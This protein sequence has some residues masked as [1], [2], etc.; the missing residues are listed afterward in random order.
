M[1]SP[2]DLTKLPPAAQKILDPQGP[3]PLKA[4]AAKAVVPGLKPADLLVVVVLLADGDG[5]AAEIARQT[6]AKLPPPVLNGAL[7][8]DLEPMV[9]GRLV[10]AYANDAA[11]MERLL[12]MPRIALETVETAAAKCSEMVAE[13]IAVNEQRML[14]HPP[15]IERLYMN[16]ATRMSTADRIIELAV[17]NRLELTGIPAYK[18][19]AI[20]IGQELVSEPTEEPTPDDILFRETLE[21][22]KALGFNPE[23]EDTHEVSDEGEE[24]VAKKFLPLYARIGT[25]T[26][27]QKIRIAMLGSAA[28]RMLLMRD[29]NRLVAS[30]AIRSPLIQEPE[31]VRVSASRVVSEEVLR[32]VSLNK[33]WVRNYQVKVNLVQN[34]RT[35]FPTAARLV[36]YLREHELKT[37]AKS[38]NVTGPIAQAAKQQL[39]RKTK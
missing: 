21:E 14:A 18:E 29:S 37:I 1:I 19:V 26:I 22:G 3:A 30:A 16:K 38:K 32:T 25:M 13:L 15:I 10:V 7:G 11:V 36:P 17:R 8:A 33:D 6:L 24:Q 28:E 5:P 34:P 12:G 27:A 2:I 31:V 23:A 20:A 4:M 39:S 9:I 35:P